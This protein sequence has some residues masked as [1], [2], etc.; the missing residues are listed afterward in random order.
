MA[1]G[2]GKPGRTLSYTVGLSSAQLQD[3]RA[4]QDE[5]VQLSD[6]SDLSTTRP[7]PLELRRRSYTEAETEGPGDGATTASTLAEMESQRTREAKMRETA[8][9][10]VGAPVTPT[11]GEGEGPGV[12]R[13]TSKGEAPTEEE[14][15]EER[16]EEETASDE[17]EIAQELLV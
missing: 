15:E 12:S 4:Q 6:S 1:D 14:E 7:S 3:R 17:G 16:E 9:Q 8:E 11:I 5:S 2:G 13:P 10:F